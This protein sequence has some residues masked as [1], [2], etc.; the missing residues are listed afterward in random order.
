MS[1]LGR[2]RDVSPESPSFM[3]RSSSPTRSARSR[4][5]TP[6]PGRRSPDPD[7][8][9]PELS[10]MRSRALMKTVDPWGSRGTPDSAPSRQN[11]FSIAKSQASKFLRQDSKIT[12]EGSGFFAI[13]FIL[14]KGLEEGDDDYLFRCQ[15]PGL[16][17]DGFGSLCEKAA[18]IL[19]I[20]GEWC[21]DKDAWYDSTKYVPASVCPFLAFSDPCSMAPQSNTSNSIAVN[22]GGRL[23]LENTMQLTSLPSAFC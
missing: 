11:S 8:K 5:A 1:P 18:N 17:K 19:D 3:R 23:G 6:D 14:L 9:T 21:S 2:G 10:R 15:L 20:N 16:Q 22:I 12:R 4:S 7:R 13:E